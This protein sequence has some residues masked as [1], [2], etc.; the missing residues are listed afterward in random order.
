MA[1]GKIILPF[2]PFLAVLSALA[3]IS[4]ALI[5]AFRK[6]YGKFFSP[7]FKDGAEKPGTTFSAA[8]AALI[9]LTLFLAVSN[10][11]VK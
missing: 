3:L 8:P 10:L 6:S 11:F 9:I 4:T 5:A 1:N 7:L 2:I